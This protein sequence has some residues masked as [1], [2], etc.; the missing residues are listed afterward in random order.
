MQDFSKTALKR[1][2]R[3]SKP[4]LVKLIVDM[5]NYAESHK[6]DNIVLHAAIT[7]LREKMAAKAASETQQ[8]VSEVVTEASSEISI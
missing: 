6:A 5:S 8:S 7:E 4:A 1:L 3:L 2:N